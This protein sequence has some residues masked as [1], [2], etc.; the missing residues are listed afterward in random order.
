MNSNTEFNIIA[1]L[2]L[3]PIKVKLMNKESGEG[4]SLEQANAVEFE[5]RRFLYVMK[6]FP[7]EQTAP[8]VD[9]DIFWH[10][11]IL[12]T[13]KYAAD[14]EQIFG[15]FL[16]HVPDSGSRGEDDEAVH[17]DT[18]ARMQELYEATFGEAY[19]RQAVSSKAAWCQPSTASAKT[20]WCQPSTASAKTAWCQPSTASAKT[21]WC[22]PSTASAKTA[23]CQ[24][25]TASARTAW[26]Q[27]STA[28]A[29]TAWCQPATEKTA[30][31]Q[32]A[33]AIKARPRA[34]AQNDKF[35]SRPVLA[36]A[37]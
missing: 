35:Y 27:P 24:P 7:Q 12:D 9:V 17:H 31:C 28:S 5:Y 2:D 16:H 23:W 30:W 4:W 13:R 20:A 10:H 11:H 14:C 18:G 26:C 33:T 22:Q 25:S 1:E 3:D 8:L 19:I 6:L 32:P 15:Y 36:R 34:V 37:A 21:A 29:K